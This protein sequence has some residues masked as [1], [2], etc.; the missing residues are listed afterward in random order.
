MDNLIKE[1]SQL[2][3]NYDEKHADLFEN[4]S[5][6]IGTETKKNNLGKHFTNNYELYIYAF[7]LGLYS[8]FH[9]P[10]PEGSKKKNFSYLI[11]GWGKTRDARR[12]DF[13]ELQNYIFMA[14]VAKTDLNFID[15]EKG[16]IDVREIRRQLQ[17][18]LE[19]Y[20]NGGLIYISEKI[21]DNTNSFLDPSSF[22]REI[23]EAPSNIKR[24]RP[25]VKANVT[26]QVEIEDDSENIN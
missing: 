19:S 7:F 22:L 23:K 17:A 14:V 18:T 26:E 15:L 11:E 2:I 20:T 1:F 12:N 16:N 25:R 3:P 10:I 6:K 21:E 4:L 8:E 24:K 13:S 9:E 5:A